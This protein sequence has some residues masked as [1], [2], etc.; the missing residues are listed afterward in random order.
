M[1]EKFVMKNGTVVTFYSAFIIV[2]ENK[3]DQAY[4]E[5]VL[6]IETEKSY[7]SKSVGRSFVVSFDKFKS[8]IEG[9]RK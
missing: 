3:I 6:N 7:K 1:N 5:T 8:I 9:L 2:T 4:V